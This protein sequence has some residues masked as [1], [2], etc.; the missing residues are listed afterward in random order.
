LV[1]S[2]STPGVTVKEMVAEA[3]LVGSGPTPG[4]GVKGMVGLLLPKIGGR[5]P[6]GRDV[7]VR[8]SSD[9]VDVGSSP[10]V[11]PRP[12]KELMPSQTSLGSVNSHQSC[13]YRAVCIVLGKVDVVGCVIDWAGIL[14]ED[15]ARLEGL[16]IATGRCVA[17]AGWIGWTGWIW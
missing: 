6:G 14:E 1:R 8:P 17:S 2:G 15:L 11:S 10:G 13:R 16:R 12:Q 7:T 3:E 9:V 5:T 4:V